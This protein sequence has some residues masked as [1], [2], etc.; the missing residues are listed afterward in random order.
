MEKILLISASTSLENRLGELLDS[1]RHLA[2][3]SSWAQARRLLTKIVPASV[4]IDADMVSDPLAGQELVHLDDVLKKDGKSAYLIAN[5]DDEH[6]RQWQQMFQ[7]LSRIVAPPSSPK[8]WTVLRDLLTQHLSNSADDSSAGAPSR[9]TP[10]ESEQIVLRLPQITSGSLS[11]LS[12]SRVMYCLHHQQATGILH[13]R[14][15]GVERG[16]AFR[17][18][19]FIDSSQHGDARV[20][21]GAYAWPDGSFEF[22]AHDHIA[23]PENNSIYGLIKKGLVTH[24]SQRQLM[25]GLMSRMSTYPTATQLWE[26]RRGDLRWAIL[27][28]FLQHCDGHQTLETIFSKMGHQITDAFRAAVFCRDTDL[29]VFRGQQT[30]GPLRVQYDGVEARTGASTSRSNSSASSGSD[31]RRPQ[32]A[33]E[34]AARFEKIQRQ[35]PHAIFGVWKG[36]GREVVKETYYSMVKQ[37][38]PDVYGGN[39]SSD[40]RDY[41]QKIFVHIRNAYTELLQQED[42]Q[43]VPPPNQPQ[44]SQPK[45]RPGRRRLTTLR[46]GQPLEAPDTAAPKRP[47]RPRSNTPIAMG[48]TPTSMHP[49]LKQQLG[50][51]TSAPKRTTS[52]PGRSRA[53]TPPPSM[54]PRSSSQGLGDVPSDAEW[55]RKQL[56]RLQKKSKAPSRRP[57]PI[58]TSKSGATTSDDPGRQAFNLGY[59]KFKDHHYKEALSYFNQARKH[60][61][62]RKL[63]TTFYAYCLFQ[64]DPGKIDEARK[65]L[66]DIIREKDRQAL[67]DAHLF[68]G[69][70]LKAKGKEQQAFKH[71]K[72]ALALNPASRDAERQ[73]RLYER[74][75]GNADSKEKSKSGGFFKKLFKD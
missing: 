21:T 29:V 74:R 1:P 54:K 17:D 75:H 14:S 38:H 56:K 72:K 48:R 3:V 35:S 39:V 8:D 47:K 50:D 24:R 23:G 15:G 57:T 18:G 53:S 11:R 6:V 69:H 28:T 30:E 4:V 12:L 9:P 34:L 20:L 19:A 16:F 44:P 65:L 33:E 70:I 59:K 42:Q 62:S 45:V 41:A 55:R 68:L 22:I 43:T 67:P 51:E 73:I 31:S 40:V 25:N 13:L 36:C 2:R 60:D 66:K 49:D 71:F 26:Q 64:T 52:S 63:Y 27:D 58:S 10:H 37:H 5:P 46:P 61:S 7:S 32:N